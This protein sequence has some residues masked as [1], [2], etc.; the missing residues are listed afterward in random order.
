[1]ARD[2]WGL[3]HGNGIVTLIADQSDARL[4]RQRRRLTASVTDL[5]VERQRALLIGVVPSK[6][7]VPAGELSLTELELLTD[8][9]GNNCQN[10]AP[11]GDLT[12]H[13]TRRGSL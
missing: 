11:H 7:D 8:T 6:Q 9:A 1:M 13:R 3:G 12:L 4:T 2:R 10:R 5:D